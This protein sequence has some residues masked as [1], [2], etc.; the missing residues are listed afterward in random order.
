VEL[1][2]RGQVR[3]PVVG[4][5]VGLM[6]D[7]AARVL[8]REGDRVDGQVVN[9]VVDPVFNLVAPRASVV[10]DT[11]VQGGRTTPGVRAQ[12]KAGQVA[13]VARVAR[14]DQVHQ[15]VLSVKAGIPSGKRLVPNPCRGKTAALPI[16]TAVVVRVVVD[17]IVG[18]GQTLAEGLA[19]PAIGNA[20]P[21]NFRRK[22]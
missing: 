13:R 17:V 9:S 22:G 19:A 21:V 7:R 5:M 2:I 20:S 4:L 3:I 11:A 1:A 16:P 15:A 14:V 6:V 8:A 10:L 18:G 12:L